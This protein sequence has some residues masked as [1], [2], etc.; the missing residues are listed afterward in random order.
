MR[1][2]AQYCYHFVIDIDGV[3]YSMEQNGAVPP[4]HQGF[5]VTSVIRGRRFLRGRGEGGSVLRSVDSQE[6]K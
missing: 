2:F 6:N 1:Y 4:E 3:A 5:L